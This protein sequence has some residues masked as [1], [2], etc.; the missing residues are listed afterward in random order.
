MSPSGTKPSSLLFINKDFQGFVR[1]SCPFSL[2]SRPFLNPP[3]LGSYTLFSPGPAQS[4][5]TTG[6]SVIQFKGHFCSLSCV[7]FLWNCH[8]LWPWLLYAFFPNSLLM[9]LAIP[10][11]FQFWCWPG[12]QASH[13]YLS[14]LFG[15]KAG[16][17]LSFMRFLSCPLI[18]GQSPLT[19]WHVLGRKC[20]VLTP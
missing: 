11:L 3:T 20:S 1:V 7:L 12:L 2:H 14:S 19:L 13:F 8:R 5:V 16:C 10:L 17:S 4:E 15:P 18:S 6:P 9:H